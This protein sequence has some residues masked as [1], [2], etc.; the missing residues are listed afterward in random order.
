MFFWRK[1][2]DISVVLS[3]LLSLSLTNGHKAW[4][5]NFAVSPVEVSLSSKVQS[6]IITI[7]N[8]SD[9]VLR[10]QV[11]TYS[12]NQ[13]TK[14][15]MYLSDTQNMVAFPMLFSLNPGE[16]RDIRVGT[17]IPVG[18]SEKTYRINIQQLN[19][20]VSS[21]GEQTGVNIL[22]KVSIPIYLEPKK[23]KVIDGHIENIRVKNNHI[24]F[25]LKNIGNVH[26]VAQNIKVQGL[27]GTKNIFDRQRK[28]WYVLAGVSQ[29][30]DSRNF[31]PGM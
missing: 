15:N 21:S 28:G 5:S 30:Y 24:F 23:K 18:D 11:K 16:K 1:S 17:S 4:A 13:D 12:W 31:S 6:Q 25:E 20:K 2:R 8:Q 3:L 22:T 29:P 7:S 10:F 14:G 26:F 9:Q 19:S 27:S